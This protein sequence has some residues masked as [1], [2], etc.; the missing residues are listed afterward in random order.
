MQSLP[1]AADGKASFELELPDNLTSWRVLAMAVTP[2]DEMGLGVHHFRVNKLTEL[3]PVMPNQITEG[4]RFKAGFTLMNRSDKPRE[5]RVVSQASGALSESVDLTQ[6]ILAEPYKR[7]PIWLPVQSQG[8]GEIRFTAQAGDSLDRDGLVH[9]VPV[10]KRRSLLT[11][12]NYGTTNEN[13]IREPVQIPEGVYPDVGSLGMVLSPSVLGNLDGAVRYVRDYPYWCWEQR[14]SKAILASQYLSLRD[15]MAADLQWPEANTLPQQMLDDAAMFQAPNGGMVFWIAQDQYVSPYLS[16]YTALSFNWL[17]AAGHKVPAQVETKLHSYLQQLL[18]QDLFP[19]FY[20]AGMASSVR[21]VALAAL[22]ERQAVSLADFQRYRAALP[23]MDLFGKAH[24]LQAASKLP[25][26]EALVG[27]TLQMILGQA[28]QSGGKFQFNERW[29]DSYAQI[30][31][32]PLR[33]NCAV[34]TA[35]TALGEQKQWTRQIGNMPFQMVRAITQTRGNRDHWENTQE[36]VF[37]LQSLRE[38]SKVYESVKPD[39]KLTVAVDA[40]AVGSNQFSALRDPMVTH[41]R[42]LR[43]D[44]I[45]QRRELVLLKSGPGRVYYSSRLQYAPT[46]ENSERI[47]AGIDVRRE[48]S[49]ERNGKWHLLES[50]MQL[51]RGELIRVDL[52]VSVPTAR[53]FVVVDDP[54]PGALEPVNRQL[55]TT[56]G[57]DADKGEFRAAG[58]SWWFQ[59]N[60]WHSYATSLWN[61]YHRELRF[62]S[63]RFYADYLPPGNYHLSYSAQVIA[64]GQFRA[65]PTHVEEMYDPDVFGKALPA[66]LTVG[67]NGAEHA[68]P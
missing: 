68:T 65:A 48:Y 53:H 23:Q 1:V 50:P 9:V 30:L 63:A 3:R 43:A 34:L 6:T 57:V 55:A 54:V 37:C 47:N 15:Y 44:D 20:S 14:L 45:G 38:Y 5:L 11:A 17:R 58:G 16:A 27:E 32:T 42:P 49:V 24:Y 10:K 36:N 21:A 41:S 31:A 60:D 33:S 13:E 56:S 62:D 22:V 61:F 67:E 25:G 2:T 18:R 28:S 12:A 52:Y 66:E 35:V 40:E 64:E 39:M 51:K 26:A 8:A 59:Y 46:L 29:D 19:T 7:I 4:D